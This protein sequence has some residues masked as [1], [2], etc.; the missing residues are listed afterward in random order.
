MLMVETLIMEQQLSLV[1][2]TI[3]TNLTTEN[4]IG[5][6]DGLP[7]M[8]KLLLFNLLVLLMMLSLD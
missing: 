2:V 7:L 4:Y 3:S 8:V 5:I 1:Q 6:S